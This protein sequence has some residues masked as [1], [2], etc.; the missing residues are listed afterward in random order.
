MLIMIKN[1]RKMKKPA[2]N[3]CMIDYRTD[4]LSHYF[5]T[6]DMQKMI[7]DDEVKDL[8]KLIH[9]GNQDAINKLVCSNLRYVISVAKQFQHRGICLEDLIEEGNIGLLEAAKRYDET[10]GTKFITYADYWICESIKNAV[11]NNSRIIRLPKK[12]CDLIW[13]IHNVQN[14]IE[15]RECRKAEPWE[16]AAEMNI[17]VEKVIELLS[18]N[19][20]M[21]QIDTPTSDDD[22]RTMEE[23][24]EHLA[25]EPI[26]DEDLDTPINVRLYEAIDTV[27]DERE[28]FIIKHCFGLNCCSK[29]LEEVASMLYISTERVRQ[30]RDK[31][32]RKLH[33]YLTPSSFRFCG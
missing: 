29:T 12:V 23:T 19:G 22:S 28:S 30:L 26:K 5:K 21:L 27:L 3:Q 2:L 14:L 33:D 9:Q 15:Q 1:T 17:T 16:I 32:Q 18:Q 11:Y 25:Y 20:Y 7:S 24:N 31:A 4:G 10:A 13:K 6:V 8:A